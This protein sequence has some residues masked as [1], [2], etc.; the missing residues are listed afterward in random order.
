MV[1]A[2]VGADRAAVARAFA[3]D[4]LAAA[5]VDSLLMTLDPDSSRVPEWVTDRYF[6]IL[7]M[8]DAD[9]R[10]ELPRRYIARAFPL[11]PDSIR[12]E[13]AY[14][15]HRRQIDRWVFQP[16]AGERLVRWWRSRDP[17]P[18]T[19][20]NEAVE[21]HVMRVARSLRVYAAE[22]AAGYDDRGEVYVRLGE[23]HI[24]QVIDIRRSDA[25][26]DIFRFG[27]PVGLHDFPD[28]EVWVYRQIHPDV[29]FI[30]V[31]DRG[32]YRIGGLYDMIPRPLRSTMSGSERSANISVSTLATIRYYL[33]RLA[34]VVVNF[35]PQ[36]SAVDNYAMWQEEQRTLGDM[37]SPGLTGSVEQVVGTGFTSVRVFSNPVFGI[38]PMQTVVTQTLSEAATNDRQAAR[39]RE[40]RAPLHATDVLERLDQEELPLGVRIS[41]FL[42]DDGST[43]AYV[44]WSPQLGGLHFSDR[45]RES[46]ERTGDDLYRDIVIDATAIGY[47]EAFRRTPL[48]DRTI[49]MKGPLTEETHLLPQTFTVDSLGAGHVA[50]QVDQYVAHLREGPPARVL[51]G[52]RMKVGVHEP[53]PVV[54]LV[55]DRRRLEM[56]DIRPYFHPLPVQSVAGLDDPLEGAHP[57]P[58]RFVPST[59]SLILTFD[60]YHLLFGEEDAV[61]YDIEYEVARRTPEGGLA[62][63][64]GRTRL[65]RTAARTRH[66]STSRNVSEM[67]VLDPAEWI[68]ETEIIVTVRA[69]DSVGGASVE[70][71]LRFGR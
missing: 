68:D 13:V 25:L 28:S 71:M 54:P 10:A 56:S 18:A 17:L 35:G 21:E 46:L 27:V 19:E 57:F 51:R 8:H 55:S 5:A 11:L 50:L 69:T 52:R 58:Y 61:L 33:E 59:G 37:G 40:E 22:V 31:A 16:G 67:I 62:G 9:P 44:D 7:R 64:V 45:R 12:A 48:G 47:D 42:A 34:L 1:A 29:Y 41:R 49:A 14:E 4:S 30:F 20:R 6:D 63:I 53:A 65:D 43:R 32:G 24:A 39:T 70:R 60:I 38:Q 3:A 66:E 23:P 26:R 36:Y 15:T 2:A